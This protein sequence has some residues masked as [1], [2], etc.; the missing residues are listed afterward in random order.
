MYRN[1][2]LDISMIIQCDTLLASSSKYAAIIYLTTSVCTHKYIIDSNTVIYCMRYSMYI[3]TPNCYRVTAISPTYFL[4]HRENN[5]FNGDKI[6]PFRFWPVWKIGHNKKKKKVRKFK[7]SSVYFRF[8]GISFIFF[9]W[10][11][12]E[13]INYNWINRY[14]WPKWVTLGSEV[15]AEFSKEEQKS[16]ECW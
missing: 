12:N 4:C 16:V 3:M 14:L 9:Y 13:E 15:P 5:L 10:N 2:P 8:N 11:L 6:L 7:F 1:Y